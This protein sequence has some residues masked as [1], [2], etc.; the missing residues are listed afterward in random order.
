MS[1]DAQEKELIMLAKRNGLT[2]LKILRESKSAKAPGRPVFAEM[3]KLLSSGK[4]AGII[5]WKLDRLARNP[6]DGGSISW[7]LQNSQIKNIKTPERDYFPSDN[8][9]LMSV[10]FGMSNQYI[11]DLS[12]NVK[13]GNREKLRRGEWPNHAPFGYLNDKVTKLIVINQKKSHWVVRMFELYGSGTKSFRDI[14]DMLYDEGLRNTSGTKVFKSAVQK[15]VRNPF[16]Y[17]ILAREGLSYLS[18]HPPLISKELFDQAQEVLNQTSRPK[19][20]SLF[21]SL[22]GPLRCHGCGCMLTASTKKG[23]HYYYC[24]NGKGNCEQGKSYLREELIAE[25]IAD[26]FTDLHFDEELIEIMYQAAKEKIGIDDGRTEKLTYNIKNELSLIVERE[27]RLTDGFASGSVRNELY[28]TKIAE[29]NNRRVELERQLAGLQ[30]KSI[31]EIATLERT[32]EVFLEANRAKTEFLEAK[33]DKRYKI[34]NTLLWNVWFKDKEIQELR[35]KTPYSIIANIPK[36]SSSTN[37]LPEHDINITMQNQ[38]I[39]AILSD[40]EYMTNLWNKVCFIK[41][42][43]KGAKISWSYL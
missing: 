3:I 36:N 11:R 10:E 38:E 40:S 18:K 32:K 42:A 5:C 43:N 20:K 34:L 2:V 24:T 25:K 29:L 12:E 39:I 14:S 17:G 30:S 9:L 15:I 19:K 23:F 4:A 6:I 31:Y 26:K 37:L 1:L 28:E 41:E 7:L 16:Y 35:Y 33:D 27:S 8:V 22:R 13:R 21:F